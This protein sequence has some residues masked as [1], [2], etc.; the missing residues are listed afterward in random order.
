MSVRLEHEILEPVVEPRLKVVLFQGL[1]R[2][3]RM[4]WVV[5]KATEVGVSAIHPFVSARAEPR[6]GGEKK[7]ER[8]RRIAVE[9]CKQCGRRQVPRI[10]PL[11]ALPDAPP[12]DLRALLLQPGRFLENPPVPFL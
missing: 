11:E 7:L 12:G 5:Q 6:G 1:L 8:W 2:P 9:S 4:D 10:E 3:E